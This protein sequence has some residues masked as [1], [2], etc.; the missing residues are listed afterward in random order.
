MRHLVCRTGLFDGRRRVTTTYD[1]CCTL[2]GTLSQYLDDSVGTL[3]KGW[4]L[5]D[6]ERAIPDDGLGT[7]ESLT[8]SVNGLRA[9]IHD[10]PAGRYLVV[11]DHFVICIGCKAIGDH[12]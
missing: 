6:S 9:N 3:R 5:G 12:H 1:G 8:K 10:A 4:H 11:R 2:G 7:F